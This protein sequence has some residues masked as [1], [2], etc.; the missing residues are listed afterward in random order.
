MVRSLLGS[1]PPVPQVDSLDKAGKGDDITLAII[2]FQWQKFLAFHQENEGKVGLI[3]FHSYF[4]HFFPPSSEIIL[5][6]HKKLPG[7]VPAGSFF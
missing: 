6:C 2:I 3:I 7:C 4:G 5:N 1:G